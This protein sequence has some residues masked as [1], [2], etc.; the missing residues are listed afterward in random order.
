MLLIALGVV[1]IRSATMEKA[2][3]LQQAAL[4]QVIFAFT[5]LVLMFL[6]AAFDY[7]LL[8]SFQK[9]LYVL[10]LALLVIVALFGSSRFG[11]Q[12]TLWEGSFQPSEIIKVLIVLVLAKYFADRQK[13]AHQLISVFGSL[14]LVAPAVALVYVQPDLDTALV[15]L[16]TWLVMALVAGMRLRHLIAF[17]V[18]GAFAMPA[19][20][21]A[22]KDYMRQRLIYFL[23]PSLEPAARYSADQAL[24]S[25]GSGGWL[26]KGYMQGT[27]THLR[28]LLLPHSDFI[29]SVIGEELGFVGAVAVIVLLTVVLFRFLRAAYMARDAFG[30]NIAIGMAA[31]IFFQ[32]A[33]NIGMNV[34]LLPVTG[35]PLPFLTYGGSALW[36]LLIGEGFVQSVLLRHKMT[37]FAF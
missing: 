35:T 31:F 34:S 6:V 16:W 17:G 33:V 25:I 27:Q 37:E 15:L 3:I 4:R 21:L 10:T 36:T 23:M 12:R 14:L 32:A 18:L 8:N 19:A 7:R 29:F 28:F 5:G 30:R 20:W 26:G 1:M 22:M 9:L 11:A 24:V 13:E 2:P